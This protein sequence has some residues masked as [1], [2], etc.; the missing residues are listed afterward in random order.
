MRPTLTFRG[1]NPSRMF[2][3]LAFLL[4]V[5]GLPRAHA[6]DCPAF[7]WQHLGSTASELVRPV[8]LVLVAGAGVAPGVFAPT[9]LDH[10]LRLAAQRDLGGRHDIEPVSVY[11][12]YVLGGGVLIGYVVTL[13][14]SACD[15]QRPQA[16][17]LQA[18]VF[19][20]ATT[21]LLK[22]SVGRE[23]PNAGLDPTA[24]DRLRHPEFAEHFSPFGRYGAWPSG[25]TGFFFAAA[26]AFRTSVPELGIVRWVGYPL[27][28]GVAAGMWI[29][30]HHWASDIISGALLGEAIGSSVGRGFASTKESEAALEFG[31][32][33]VR[34]GGLV[35]Q[36]Y[37]VW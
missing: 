17:M 37:G 12:P 1:P 32:V 10:D 23:W 8:P 31:V 24:P 2:A 13:A 15:A 22:F 36:A 18:M 14:V 26:S 7:P 29:G 19:S 35:A 9:G 11:A 5:L 16:A 25:H 27:S 21:A 30:D 3:G 33:P 34:G 6:K 4:V 28:L 20:L